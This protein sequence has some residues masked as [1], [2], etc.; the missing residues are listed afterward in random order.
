MRLQGD[1][2]LNRL[3]LKYTRSQAFFMIYETNE[4]IMGNERVKK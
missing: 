2:F 3:I 4:G 1:F